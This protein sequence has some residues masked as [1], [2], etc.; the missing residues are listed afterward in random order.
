MKG[1]DMS[2]VEEL[3]AKLEASKQI[4]EKEEFK[5]LDNKVRGMIYHAFKMGWEESKKYFIDSN[6]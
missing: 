5:K 2:S 4:T 3:R 1:N 6:E